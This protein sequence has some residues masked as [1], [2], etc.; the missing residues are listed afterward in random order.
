MIFLLKVKVTLKTIKGRLIDGSAQIGNQIK[1]TE[2][3]SADFEVEP[4]EYFI[5]ATSIG[6]RGDTSHKHIEADEEITILMKS[7]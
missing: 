2:N 6:Y 3:G 4:G 1:K 5:R 7:W